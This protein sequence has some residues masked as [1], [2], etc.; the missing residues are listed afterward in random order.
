MFVAPG[1]A[2]YAT[3]SVGWAILVGGVPVLMNGY[4]LFVVWSVRWRQRKGYT[5]SELGAVPLV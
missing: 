5:G 4:I 1:V 2:Y 3:G